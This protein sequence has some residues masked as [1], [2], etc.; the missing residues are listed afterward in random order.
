MEYLNACKKLLSH[1]S[2]GIPWL[3]IAPVDAPDFPQETDCLLASRS[4]VRV[5]LLTVCLV[6]CL[7]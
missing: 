6:A 2:V 7:Q 3:C 1:P 5:M 4:L